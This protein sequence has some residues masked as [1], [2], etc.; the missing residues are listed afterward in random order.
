MKKRTTKLAV[1]LRGLPGAGKSSLVKALVLAH[2]G[3]AKCRV[4]T[5]DDFFI[6]KKGKYVF[7][8]SK[9]FEFHTRNLTAFIESCA[10][11]APLVICDNTNLVPWNF[12][13]YVAAA[14]SLGYEV[15]VLTVGEFTDEAIEEYAKRNA[16]GVP[17][18]TLK[19]M[20][21]SFSLT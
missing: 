9:L 6:D 7:D 15:Q 11:G 20:R 16:H 21:N 2:G 13:S 18:A 4:H 12:A 17:L 14:K 19:A 5:T 1:I 3:A 10:A 8:F